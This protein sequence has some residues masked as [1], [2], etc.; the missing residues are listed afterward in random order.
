MRS[1]KRIVFAFAFYS[2]PVFAVPFAN[3]QGDYKIISCENESLQAS[4]ADRNLCDYSQVVVYPLTIGSMVYFTT[5]ERDAWIRAFSFPANTGD[6]PGSS[7]SEMNNTYAAYSRQNKDTG[8]VTILRK[9]SNGTYH[10]SLHRR[11]VTY[12][13]FDKFELDLEKITDK[14]TPPPPPPEA[15]DEEGQ[16][17]SPDDGNGGPIHD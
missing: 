2:L 6:Y 14:A 8:E 5:G 3:M 11:S 12:K 13:F 10:L 16:S 7:Y 15:G 17:C 4:P 1:L 9:N